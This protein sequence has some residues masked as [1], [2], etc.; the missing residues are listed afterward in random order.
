[1]IALTWQEGLQILRPLGLFVLGVVVYAVFVFKFYLFLSRRDIVKADLSR[2]NTARHPALRKTVAGFFY[3]LKYLLLMP[4]FVFFWFVILTLLL[5]FLSKNRGIGDILLIAMAVVG[6]VRIT[7]YYNEDLS[8]DLAKMLPFALL[9]IFLVD[10]TYFNL[11]ASLD[12]LA[13]I[14]AFI[15]VLAYY[16]IGIIALELVLRILSGLF[17]R[18]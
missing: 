16:F 15:S 10:V 9:G 8:K 12:M 1:M 11:G 14:P 3:L 4:L 2:Y 13:E 6:A 17:S 5:T 18:S 7:S